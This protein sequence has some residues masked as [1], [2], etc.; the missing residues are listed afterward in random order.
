MFRFFATLMNLFFCIVLA[1]QQPVFTHQQWF[2]VEN[3]L[4]QNYISG[5]AEDKE[6]FLWIATRDGLARYDGRDFLVFRQQFN[7][8]NSLRSSVISQILIDKHNYIWLLYDNNS[9]DCFDPRTFTVAKRFDRL[10]I[11]ET[12]IESDFYFFDNE[13]FMIRRMPRKGIAVFDFE[14]KKHL[15]YERSNG[16]LSSDSVMAFV[17]DSIGRLW[18]VSPNGLQTTDKK[19][20]KFQAIPFPA[21]IKLKH[22]SLLI[23]TIVA[24][25]A[26]EIII[27]DEEK[28]IIYNIIKK[29]FR[30]INLPRII[31]N[32]KRIVRHIQV[33][34]DGSC[35]FIYDAKLFKLEN[36]RII[37]LW[38]SPLPDPFRAA[39]LYIDRSKVFWYGT[40]AG[41]LM[42]VDLNGFPITSFPYR[43]NFYVD[44]LNING[45]PSKLLPDHSLKE[46]MAYH[47]RY[48]YGS[49]GEMFLLLDLYGFHHKL[50]CWQS[51]KLFALPFPSDKK[52]QLRGV[53]VDQ[54]GN[55]WAVDYL[56]KGV[57]HWKN[58]QSMP[59]FI[60]MGIL[61][62][63]STAL[64][65]F[66]DLLVI[67]GDF[68]IS[69]EESG[70]Y[71]VRNG[72]I[73][74][75]FYQR[76]KQK[77]L[78]SDVLND[79]CR[80]PFDPK[81]FWVG[82]LGGGLMLMD[83]KKGLERVFTTADKLPNNTIYGI[84]PDANGNLWLSTNKGICRFN[85]KTHTV[86]HFNTE[87]GLTGE[88][89][90]RFH[91]FKFPDG[92]IAFGGLDGYSIL[93]PGDFKILKTEVPVILTKITVNNQVQDFKSNNSFI[94][95]P[96]AELK[97][98]DLPYYKNNLVIEFAALWFNRPEKINYRYMLKEFDENWIE[99]G[100]DNVARYTR[101]RPGN[102]KLLVN[103]TNTPGEWGGN[104][105][106]ISI[107]IFP[108]VWATWW[109]YSIY[110]MIIAAAIVWY[111]RYRENMIRIK[112]QI[113]FEHR[114][115]ARLKEIDKFKTRFFNNI[116]H[117]FRTPL[118]LI[119]APVRKLYNDP[120][121]SEHTKKILN[122]VNRNA[123]HLLSLINLMLD[124]SKLE[125]RQMAIHLSSGDLT[126]F[127]QECVESFTSM[128]AEKNISLNFV[129]KGLYGDFL[130]DNEKFEKILFNLL[131]N[132][133]KFTPDA[134][135]ITV[136]F[137]K[138]AET[139]AGECILQITVK[140]TGIG[141]SKENLTKVF[142]RFY[143][144]D[145]SETRQYSGTGIGLALVKEFT[146]FL[147]GS[148]EVESE[149]GKGT[150]FKID[151]PISQS[152]QVNFPGND[153]AVPFIT[154]A[155]E[156]AAS[157]NSTN[158]IPL[159][160]IAED[161]HELRSF[162]LDSLSENWRIITAADGKTAWKEI[163]KELPEIV[164]SDAM[165]PGFD[166]FELCRLVKNDKRTAHIGFIMLTAR[167]AH[168][169][170]M[171][172]LNAGADEYITKPFHPDELE[173]RIRNLM[174]LQEK[175]REHLRL[176]LLSNQPLPVLPHVNDLFIQ[177]LY[178]IVDAKIDDPQLDVDLLSR[179]MAMSRST[180]NRKL[181]ALV[182]VSANELVR[183][184]R[185][186]KAVTL[187]A[188][189]HDITTT[190]YTV[191][192]N[193]PSYFS[194]CFKE[195]Y[196]KSP[197][198]YAVSKQG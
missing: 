42:K 118:S 22:D 177:Q 190:A 93:N 65:R 15:I 186:Q 195:Q 91:H 161:N 66:V 181:N 149:P 45:I 126:T 78:S 5:L 82:S 50:Y 184:Y 187:L 85:L 21:D 172:G 165:M 81:K 90:N 142:D 52:A 137:E 138:T 117:E 182:G 174:R 124:L 143:Q 43:S 94:K 48:A 157:S 69:S 51:G 33:Y 129:S 99:S 145:N 47:F 106:E 2:K 12:F 44:V 18:M 121:L 131:S 110:F 92:R 84:V 61:P 96:L 40:N 30:T 71:Q 102:Y 4:P 170:R 152:T 75:R 57:W 163:L 39:K 83:T 112:E 63:N 130:F 151:L 173:T 107:R 41:G 133:I 56:N 59:E 103:A 169:S 122:G 115:T 37:L 104:I 180:L 38:K 72:K 193:T 76:S 148:I 67:D 3:G 101:L 20:E 10:S 192:F 125:A 35:Y 191:G 46:P 27:V 19:R 100:N 168:S 176:E 185:L 155:A 159:I 160:L 140:D 24:N 175:I 167:A 98:I 197:S 70:L 154:R 14:T 68:W 153:Q 135:E 189:G 150:I 7:E 136:I 120:R 34:K 108:P 8:S 49:E 79:L 77:P 134:G 13:W 6:G 123:D 80:D 9:V 128:A 139:Q 188:A 171:E 166:G 88:E 162:L 58:K 36:D 31:S 25:P 87:D 113:A 198:E 196:G 73:I 29:S 109:A 132:A 95:V 105:R 164:V 17:H 97:K 116:T 156:T 32:E 60:G 89:F 53:D 194:E 147:K 144:V 178:K 119:I 62:D 179:S 158:S 54:K 1:A 127:G 146:E 64:Y 74:N 16:Y 86:N 141:I 114:E 23:A 11:G 26:G 28:F 183:R 55:I 111:F